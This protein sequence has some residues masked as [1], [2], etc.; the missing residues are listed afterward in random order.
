MEL[1]TL[2]ADINS[3]ISTYNDAVLPKVAEAKRLQACIAQTVYVLDQADAACSES[4]EAGSLV[5]EA[6][7]GSPGDIVRITT[8]IISING[9]RDSA[10]E[11]QSLFF[12]GKYPGNTLV[13]IPA[14]TGTKD[15]IGQR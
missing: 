9:G 13:E 2:H 15:R 5:G 1:E 14:L 4:Q 11:R 6:E 10:A 3:F 12:K 7:G 8:Y